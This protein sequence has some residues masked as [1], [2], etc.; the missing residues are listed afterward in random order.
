MKTTNM[1]VNGT[2]NANLDTFIIPNS[3]SLVTDWM[4]PSQQERMTKKAEK[5]S[6]VAGCGFDAANDKLVQL[7]FVGMGSENLVDHA[8]MAEDEN[9]NQYVLCADI[10]RLP[11]TLFRGHKEGDVIE[12]PLPATCKGE[13]GNIEV[14]LNAK[15]KL[16][17]RDY[18]YRRFGNFEE[19]LA[20]VTA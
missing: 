8:T 1:I 18:R 13:D 20:Q 14:V 11:E 9:G 3:A 17:Q 5:I 16:N 4:T 15:I 2:I 10:E 6:A 12:V 19:V 7:W